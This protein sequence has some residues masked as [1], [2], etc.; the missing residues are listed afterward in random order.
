MAE[1]GA[2]DDG[3]SG[4]RAIISFVGSSP[5]NSGV[6]WWVIMSSNTDRSSLKSASAS[7]PLVAVQSALC[8]VHRSPLRLQHTPGRILLQQEG[9]W[10]C[11]VSLIMGEAL[12]P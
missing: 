5:V 7:V 6:V 10:M 12:R 1:A 8:A 2:E 9:I 11:T 4:R 3:I